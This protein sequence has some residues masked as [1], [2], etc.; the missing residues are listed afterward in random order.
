MTGS[1]ATV[2]LAAVR[3]GK[4]LDVTNTSTS[5]GTSLIQWSCNGGTNQK[6]LRTAA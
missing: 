4:C 3:S 5:E 6:W 2:Q 1:G